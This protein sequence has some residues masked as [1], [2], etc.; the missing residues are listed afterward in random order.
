MGSN[1]LAPLTRSAENAAH[2]CFLLCEGVR[3]VDDRDVLYVFREPSGI[4]T[5]WCQ[6]TLVMANG[7][8]ISGRAMTEA[9]AALQIKLGEHLRAA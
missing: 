3:S 9:M 1:V 2:G 4:E 5:R 8:E 6:V 7:E